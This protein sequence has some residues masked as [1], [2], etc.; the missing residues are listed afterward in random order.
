MKVTVLP[1]VVRALETAGKNLEKRHRKLGIQT[2]QTTVCEEEEE[3]AQNTSITEASPSDGL[4]SYQG[5]R[6][7]SFN[8]LQRCSQYNPSWLS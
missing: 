7:R 2:V 1:I 5:I 6:W 8:P 4:V 3:E